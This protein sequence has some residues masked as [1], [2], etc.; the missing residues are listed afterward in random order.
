MTEDYVRLLTLKHGTFSFYAELNH[1]A[2][3]RAARAARAELCEECKA[4]G[5]NPHLVMLEVELSRQN[6]N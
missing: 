4:M 2:K 1:E 3:M 5:V 6:L